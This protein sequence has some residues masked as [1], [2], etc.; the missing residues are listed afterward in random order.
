[1]QAYTFQCDSLATFSGCFSKMHL[2]HCTVSLQPTA[3]DEELIPFSCIVVI[4]VYACF[5]SIKVHF[6]VF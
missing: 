5:F 6:N 4:I 2:K 1:M 3:A